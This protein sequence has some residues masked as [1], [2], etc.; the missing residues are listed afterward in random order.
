MNVLFIAPN[1]QTDVHRV[2]PVGALYLASAL[3]QKGHNVKFLDLMFA[4]NPVKKITAA[5]R[6][7]NADV[8]C[9]SARNI[10]IGIAQWGNV[11]SDIDDT[12]F[13][14]RKNTTNPIIMGGPGFS[15]VS[16]ELMQH[17]KPDFGIVG[18]AD[19]SLPMLLD[20][21]QHEKG[22]KDIPGLIYWETDK[23]LISNTPDTVMDLDNIPF[24]A[25]ELIDSQKYARKG[26]SLAVFT[27][28][29]CSQRCIYCSEPRING[30]LVRLRSAG[31]IADEIEYIIDKTGVTNFDF[32]DTLFNFPGRH[33]MDVCREIIRRNLKIQFEADL[34][35]LGQNT[36]SVELLKKAGCTA[37]VLGAESGSD[38]MLKT[39][40]RGY[41][42]D[43]IKSVAELYAGFNIPYMITFLIGGPGENLATVE[44]S[45]ELAESC[46]EMTA[47]GFAVGLRVSKNTQLTKMMIDKGL[48]EGNESFLE[49][50][51]FLSD[52]FDEECANRLF[53]ACYEHR[54]F[55]LFDEIYSPT[56]KP[57][58]ALNKIY[59][60]RPSWRHA[61]IVGGIMRIINRLKGFGQSALYWDN[62]LR[63]FSDKRIVSRQL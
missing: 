59:T 13:A 4:R 55:L 21:L 40:Q 53:A 57:L 19:N 2:P 10:N 16:M 50:K 26:G 8:T 43:K 62:Q 29:G 18:E 54:N 39:L 9:I 34:N 44:E 30:R 22:Y 1:R 31:R 20:S 49:P 23:G 33:A 61:P 42:A 47:A 17:L 48:L 60:F 32:S 24:Q 28:K 36:E 63:C 41:T 46:P 45:I 3:I 6:S 25:I 35:P 37:I 7:F 52:S 38:R 12:V 51:I 15:I 14:V 27:R 5:L 58:L 11:V 56:F